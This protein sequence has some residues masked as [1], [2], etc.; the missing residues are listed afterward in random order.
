MSKTYSSSGRTPATW[1]AQLS[2]VLLLL[3]LSTKVTSALPTQIPPFLNWHELPGNGLTDVSDAAVVYRSNLFLFSI[4][5]SDSH[6]YLNTF[7]G[8]SWSGWTAIPGGGTALVSDAAVVFQN[9]LYLIGIGINDHQHYVNTFDGSGWAGWSAMPGGSTTLVSDAAATFA[10]K[11]Y[12]LGIGINDHRHYVNAFDG[13]TWD[14]WTPLPGDGTTAT[15]DAVVVFN[16]RI[17]VFSV[18]INDHRHYVNQFDGASWAGW[19]EIPGAATT[20]TADS[21][22]V[23]NGRLFV[24]AIGETDRR[25]YVNEFD[26][27]NWAGW[28]P[29]NATGGGANTA[30]ADAAAV[31]NNAVNLFTIGAADGRHYMNSASSFPS[32]NQ[33]ARKATHN[34]YW[35]NGSSFPPDWGAAGVQQRVLDQALFEHVRAFEFDIHYKQSHPGEFDVYHTDNQD[36]STCYALEDCLELMRRIDYVLPN[37]EVINL[38]IEFKE[39]VLPLFGNIWGTPTNIQDHHPEDLDRLLWERLGPR[40]YTP[41]EFLERCPRGYTLH[42]CARDFGWPTIDELRGRYIV[43]VF[44]NVQLNFLTNNVASYRDYTDTANGIA[45]R[46]AFPMRVIAGGNLLPDNP[47]TCTGQCAVRRASEV[48][49]QVEDPGK[50]DLPQFFAAGGVARSKAAHVIFDPVPPGLEDDVGSI[51]QSFAVPRH[52]QMIMTDYP[53]NFIE[54]YKLWNPS[55]APSAA[56]RPFFQMSDAIGGPQTF[57]PDTLVE[58]GERIFFDTAPR[59]TAPDRWHDGVGAREVAPEKTGSA[60]ALLGPTVARIATTW[61]VFPSTTAESHSHGPRNNGE[62][63]TGCFF[64]RSADLQNEVRVCRVADMNGGRDVTVHV[65]VREQGVVTYDNQANVHKNV[66]DAFSTLGDAFRIEVLPDRSGTEVSLMTSNTVLPN[67]GMEWVLHPVN[68]A[69]GT[70]RTFMV[71]GILS[72]QGLSATNEVVFTGTT[73]NGQ[74]LRLAQLQQKNGARIFDLSFC[75]D[76]SCRHSTRPTHEIIRRTGGN[77]WVGVHETEGR[78]FGQWRTLY[79][80]DRF[81]VT[82]SGLGQFP[83]YEKFE[84]A[85]YPS[86]GFVP[87]YRCV[88]W[89]RDYHQHWLSIDVSCPNPNTKE[90]FAQNAGLMGYIST[91]PLPGTQPLW[92]LRK[93]THNAGSADTHDHY[94][95]VG[96]GERDIKRDQEGYSVVGSA[97][98][99]YVYTA[100]TLP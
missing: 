95:A 48:F 87:L 66:V 83:R 41:R 70:G 74:P 60:E 5:K 34:S 35:V 75:L 92:H 29:I 85:Q 22:V 1:V 39:D 65:T 10:G 36:N 27:T 44:G 16:N 23:F 84:V 20:M 47:A 46:A 88:D 86:S 28:A 71:N 26:G 49:W 53:W 25:H 4:G 73:L 30:N 78:V 77:V 21:A 9:R 37:H 2:I 82:T 89:R 99:G 67:G 8:T 64:A 56:D 18:G 55:Y 6:H 57:D 68:K 81:E 40:L 94:F 51:S 97:P 17:F 14:G 93:G 91:Q 32:Y 33:V 38:A 69:R 72:Q 63:G 100:S 45:T 11:L 62:P 19:N 50:Q 90:A 31:F 59:F 12:V 7:D 54:D 24:F 80:T 43:T 96:D 61:E 58:P 52:Y 42:D 15:P 79:T 13:S 76:G 98:V 3:V